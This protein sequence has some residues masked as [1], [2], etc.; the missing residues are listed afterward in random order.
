MLPNTTLARPED[1]AYNIQR[2]HSTSHT[3][4]NR[5]CSNSPS[6]MDDSSPPSEVDYAERVA[7]NCNMNIETTDPS[8]P[9]AENVTSFSFSLPASNPCICNDRPHFI[10]VFTMIQPH[11]PLLCFRSLHISNGSVSASLVGHVLYSADLMSATCIPHSL[12]MVHRYIYSRYSPV[13][14]T[15]YQLYHSLPSST[16]YSSSSLYLKLQPELLLKVVTFGK[17]S[18]T[19]LATGRTAN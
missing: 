10:Q 2:G 11:R 19:H 14:L 13:F 7:A 18:P 8:H 15:L 3:S 12:L 5:P 17:V 6:P 1:D 4:T 9:S 16:L